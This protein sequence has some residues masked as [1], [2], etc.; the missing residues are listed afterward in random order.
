MPDPLA[1]APPSS[2]TQ[3]SAPHALATQR[4]NAGVTVIGSTTG[5]P[6][7]SRDGMGPKVT[8]ARSVAHGGPGGV[9]PAAVGDRTSIAPQETSPP[10]GMR[11][12]Q[13]RLD[14]DLLRACDRGDHAAAVALLDV[15]HPTAKMP[16]GR[17]ALH[18]ASSHGWEDVTRRL[19]SKGSPNVRDNQGRTPLFHAVTT[20]RVEIVRILAAD[21]RTQD[22]ED[23]SGQLA[24]DRVTR[25]PR[26]SPVRTELDELLHTINARYLNTVFDNPDVLSRGKM[27]WQ[28]ALRSTAELLAGPQDASR[29]FRTAVRLGDERTCVSLW[30]EPGL[31]LMAPSR[32]GR[33]AL[34]H[35]A[36]GGRGR[37]AA[38]ILD[39]VPRDRHPAHAQDKDGK[40]PAH[41][42]VDALRPEILRTF[43]E[44]DSINDLPDKQGLYARDHVRHRLDQA[45]SG[46]V[47]EALERLDIHSRVI[48]ERTA[49]RQL[50]QALRDKDMPRFQ[51]WL[52]K[53][54]P[55]AM[56]D[57]F[58]TALHLAARLGNAVAVF[59]ILDTADPDAEPAAVRDHEGRTPVHHAVDALRTDV[60]EVL[61]QDGRTVDHPDH[62]G[63]TAYEAMQQ[64]MDDIEKIFGPTE[65]ERLVRCMTRIH[66]RTL[67]RASVDALPGHL[68]ELETNWSPEERKD[69][70]V[71]AL[72][73]PADVKKT[74]C[75]IWERL[76]PERVAF[77]VDL[78]AAS[79]QL[80]QRYHDSGFDNRPMFHHYGLMTA[81]AS[82]PAG[83]ELQREIFEV[84]G[85]DL[86]W[87]RPPEK[88]LG[89]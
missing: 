70:L 38:R 83:D 17:T 27:T 48:F 33:T 63:V 73:Y 31:D 45:G 26:G 42:A 36:G 65:R 32:H 71:T 25:F 34:H 86:D 75:R 4:A 80:A 68:L 77:G 78:V 53:A 64:R 3:T 40:T 49:L 60:L 9:F 8:P 28:R 21:P 89:A 18:F 7:H 59:A 82:A 41:F 52:A 66:D 19:L 85:G 12:E 72:R 22:I 5:A 30:H 44:N 16:D 15:A 6:V 50:H 79:L 88:S 20:G 10:Q 62:Q 81:G 14:A 51:T 74:A 23:V 76:P 61:A 47:P 43:E 69:I 84:F 39:T 46:P 58:E 37:L 55:L 54:D 56:A 67:F 11:P 87:T 1:I 35:A 2:L 13:A 29:R 24:H 57:D